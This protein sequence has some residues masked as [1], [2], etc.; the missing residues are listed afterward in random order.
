MKKKTVIII[1]IVVVML[2]AAGLVL[3]FVLP[4]IRENKSAGNDEENTVSDSFTSFTSIDE[5]AEKRV[6]VMTGSI[7]EALVG[8]YLPDAN[9]SFFDK[10]AD[11]AVAV[12]EGKIDAFVCSDVQAKAL[13][14][15]I[16]ALKIL[17]G[18]PEKG[19]IAFAFPKNDKGAA[20]RDE[21]NEFLA[22]IKADGT[23]DK[24]A[25]KW[26]KGE[27]KI[28]DIMVAENSRG[29]LK[30]ATTGTTEP[31]TFMYNGRLVGLD[32]DLAALFSR[33]YSYDLDISVM[34]FGSIIPGLS[35]G[36]Y[37]LAGANI[38]VTD[39]RSES[40]YF[41]ESYTYNEICFVVKS[42]ITPAQ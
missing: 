1:V 19:Y 30:M 40:V 37:D 31:Y 26:E 34:D 18:F 20:L 7:Y 39:E 41:S 8:K 9:I 36:A 28:V 3:A 2:I 6:G 17:G 38:T 11:M 4:G 25:E 24:L 14:E 32:I 21:F 33:E 10:A 15:G 35:S 16:E 29:V 42:G 12:K 27:D 5:L 13:T 23:Y 22:K